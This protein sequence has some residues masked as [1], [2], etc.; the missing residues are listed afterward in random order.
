MTVPALQVTAG[1]LVA[2]FLIQVVKGLTE[3]STN[4]ILHGVN[5]GIHALLA[6]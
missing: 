6:S 1:V 3:N 4:P 5:G 2:L